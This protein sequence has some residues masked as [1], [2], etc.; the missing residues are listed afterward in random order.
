[1]QIVNKIDHLITKLTELKPALSDDPSSNEKKFNGLLTANIAP[2][3]L[4]L[5][6]KQTLSFQNAE[7][8]SDM[9]SWVDQN[10]AYDP[11]RP[12]KPNMRELIEGMSGKN[13]EDLYK[14]PKTGKKLATKL[15][16]CSQALSVRM[17]TLEIGRR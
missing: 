10:Y 4:I 17:K 2:V 11:K 14:E 3:I 9:P 7:S 16:K 8:E 13:V 1:M 12:R 6:I 5:L 15:H